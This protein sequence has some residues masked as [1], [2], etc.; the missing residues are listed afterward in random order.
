MK[1][2]VLICCTIGLQ[3]TTLAQSGLNSIYSAYGIGDVTIRDYTGY[4]GMGGLGVAMPSTNTLNDVNPAAYG[5]FPLSRLMLELSFGGKSVNYVNN[6]QNINAGDFT[7]RKAALGFSL[8]RNWATS[9]GIKR[10]SDVEY[11]T[12]GNRFLL[13]TNSKLS[14]EIKGNGGLYEFFFSNGLKLGKKLNLGLT[15]GYLSGSVNRKE[16]I[17]TDATDGVVVD[18][19]DFYRNFY[20]NAGFQYKIKTGDYSWILGGTFQPQRSLDKTEDNTIQNLSGTTLV[21]QAAILGKF[22]FPVQWGGGLTLLKD[23]WKFGVDYIG[24]NWQSVHY[25]GSGFQTTNAGNWAAGL[26][27]GQPKKTVFGLMDGP[28]Y[29]AGINYDQSYLVINGQQ[30]KTIAGTIGISLPSR[31]G[32]YQYHFG[33]KA[34]QRGSKTYPLVRE[35]FVEFNANI[36]LSSLIYTGGRKYE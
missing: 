8:F 34:G 15:V 6:T 17:S 20:F 10:Y 21:Q 9:F 23:D 35:N 33:L 25:S 27:Y 11:Y 24:Q 31:T 2:V 1:Y 26:S 4:A 13:G 12:L 3:S 18:K 36:S 28:T 32:L 14:S 29:S 16:T 22:D 7:V 19:N 5:S 30:I